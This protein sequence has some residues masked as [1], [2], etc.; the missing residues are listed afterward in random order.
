ML[1]QLEFPSSHCAMRTRSK[2]TRSPD[3]EASPNR[4]LKRISLTTE[5]TFFPRLTSPRSCNSRSANSSRH[6]S[7]DWVQQTGG[8]SIDSP[9]YPTHHDMQDLGKTSGIEDS[10]PTRLMDEDMN[11]EPD[12]SPG[13]GPAPISSPSHDASVPGTSNSY[14]RHT[15]PQD[16]SIPT[17]LTQQYHPLNPLIHLAPMP[18]DQHMSGPNINVTPPTPSSRPMTALPEQDRQPSTSPM[19]LSPSPSEYLTVP[20]IN[21]QSKRQKFS[22]G[23]R[24]DCEKCRLGVKGHWAHLD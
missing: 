6:P 11:M 5:D 14:K 2:R 21:N 12:E 1:Q 10:L 4:P 18:L 19:I 8:L 15:H 20:S 13:L 22:M 24:A 16:P 23:P 3:I 17:P 9:V 7:E